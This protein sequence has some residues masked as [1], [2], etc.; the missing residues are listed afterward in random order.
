MALSESSEARVR[1][2]EALKRELKTLLPSDADIEFRG[3][4]LGLHF[5]TAWGR[6]D[7]HRNL[8]IWISRVALDD[9]LMPDESRGEAESKL[10][11]LIRRRLS[12]L[13]TTTEPQDLRVDSTDVRVP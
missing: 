13:N 5:S 11:A 12:S 7:E 8:Q 4:D 2:G 10:F 1:Y 3:E 9:Y 6:G